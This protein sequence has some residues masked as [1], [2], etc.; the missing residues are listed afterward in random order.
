MVEILE[1]RDQRQVTVFSM[2]KARFGPDHANSVPQRALRFIEEGIEACQAAGVDRDQLLK[3]VGF[4]YDRP[5]G[6]LNK[7]I[8]AAGLTLLGLA[9]AAGL[10]ADDEEDREVNR[11]LA[12]DPKEH[13]ARNRLKN[14][15]GFDASAY[16]IKPYSEQPF[17]EAPRPAFPFAAAQWDCECGTKNAGIRKS[18]RTCG[19]GREVRR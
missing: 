15:A 7:E 18:C 13:A 10:S 17:N 8:G 14:E 4:V 5:V 3:L 9:A 1:S 2:I 19:Q 12:M 11:V 16:P 6:E